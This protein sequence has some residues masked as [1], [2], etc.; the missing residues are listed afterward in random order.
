MSLYEKLQKA[1]SEE[2]VKDA[3]EIENFE[4]LDISTDKD[5]FYAEKADFSSMSSESEEISKKTQKELKYNQELSVFKVVFKENNKWEFFYNGVRIYASITDKDF[6][7]KVT[8]GE[9]AFRSG[10]RM[11]AD[12][13]IVQVFN[14]AANTFVN[15]AYIIKNVI[16]HI[17]R[18]VPSQDSIDFRYEGNN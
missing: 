1:S 13:E 18:S 12:M 9:I 3:D 11:I 7:V 15:E 17:P 10:D 16:Q 2:G 8:K 6:A 5:I 14:D 4:I